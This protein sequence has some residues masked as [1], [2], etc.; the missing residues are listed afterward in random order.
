[1]TRLVCA[2][3]FLAFGGVL[4]AAACSSGTQADVGLSEPIQVSGG[5][6]F[7]GPLPGSPPAAYSPTADAG[8]ALAPLSVTNVTFQNAFV[9]SGHSGTG[10]TGLVTSDAVAVGVQLENAGSGYWVVPVQS[11]DVQFAG[12][13]DFG[14]S[15]SFNPDDRTGQTQL[16]VVGIGA[17]GAAGQQTNTPLCIE[18]RVPDNGHACAP[19]VKVP[20]AVFTLTW[21]TNFDVD[22]HVVTPDGRDVNPKTAVTTVALDADKVP[23][24]VGAIDRDS[25]GECVI[26]GWREEDLV[27]QDAPPNGNYLIYASPFSSCGQAAV[28]FTFNLYEAGADGNLHSTFTRSGELLANDVTG[29]IST[30][31]FVAQ[32]TF[33]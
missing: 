27:F 13:S 22:L 11:P 31:L 25:I 5:Q 6:F 33:E 10:V 12:Q 15:L 8:S 29:G 28:V 21:N 7:S 17:N 4:T 26:D 2:V 3:A 1:M 9:V 19:S 32:K 30:G 23:P 18:S 24:T 20:K 14:F 16:R